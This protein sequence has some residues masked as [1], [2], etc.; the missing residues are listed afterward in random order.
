MDNYLIIKFISL[1]FNDELL[2]KSTKSK[3]L[4]RLKC[5]YTRRDL[6]ICMKEAVL[7]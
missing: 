4:T 3:L 7:R 6:K 2:E 5:D 1:L